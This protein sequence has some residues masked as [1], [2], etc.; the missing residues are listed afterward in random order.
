MIVLCKVLIV[1][2]IKYQNKD[3]NRFAVLTVL[4][5]TR[6]W[7][8]NSE[9][10]LTTFKILLQ[11]H[12]AYFNQTWHKAYLNDWVS[13]L[14]KERNMSLYQERYLWSS[15]NTLSKFWILLLRNHWTKLTNL[16]T[17]HLWMKGI[18]GF[19]NKDHSILKNRI[20]RVFSQINIMI[21]YNYVF[22]HLNW[23]LRWAMW[24]MGLLLF[25]FW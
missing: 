15:E 3:A 13:S 17:M 5:F 21:Y 20:M 12:F 6:R 24:P 19:T 14:F 2:A 18:Q 16:G 1:K 8:L 9:N 22:L 23:F 7:L 10:R 4:W 25:I 11:N